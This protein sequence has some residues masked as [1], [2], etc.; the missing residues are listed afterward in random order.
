MIEVVVHATHTLDDI[1]A[2]A[3][4]WVIHHQR[5][6]PA[7]STEAAA[8]L[9]RYGSLC[10]QVTILETLRTWMQEEINPRSG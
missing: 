3:L 2:L 4:G 9:A 8:Y 1:Q 7:T 6:R 5:G 10:T